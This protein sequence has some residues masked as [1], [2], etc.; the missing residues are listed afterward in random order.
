MCYFTKFYDFPNE[1]EY[2]FAF[3]NISLYFC[4]EM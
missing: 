4:S 3:F 1:K 2:Y